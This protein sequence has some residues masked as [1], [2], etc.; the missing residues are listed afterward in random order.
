MLKFINT[1]TAIDTSK[2]T[3][4]KVFHNPDEDDELKWDVKVLLD[5]GVWVRIDSREDYLDA[6]DYVKRIIAEINGVI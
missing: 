5:S 1:G 2:I 4:V 6:T 3:V